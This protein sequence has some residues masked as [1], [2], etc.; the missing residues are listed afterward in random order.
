[1][2]RPAKLRAW[3]GG[4]VAATMLLGAANAD[5]LTLNARTKAGANCS[6]TT[7]AR[8]NVYGVTIPAC[9][10]PVNEVFAAGY[11]LRPVGGGSST[12]SGGLLPDIPGLI[13]DI[14]G[15]PGLPVIPLPLRATIPQLPTL[16]DLPIDPLAPIDPSLLPISP[17]GLGDGSRLAGASRFAPGTKLPYQ[18]AASTTRSGN[19][20]R[21]ELTMRLRSKKKAP[22]KWR[23]KSG[24]DDCFVTS[25][26][27]PADTL[28]CDT[29]EP[30]GGK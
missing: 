20:V 8:V 25:T 16:P 5:A 3:I 19:K 28:Q 9:D 4:V 11:L 6:I 10:A 12:G 24:G 30:V 17:I 29:L 1:M 26:R 14:P 23:K 27:R 18:A 2:E 15:L 7:I 13:P 21:V 22:Q